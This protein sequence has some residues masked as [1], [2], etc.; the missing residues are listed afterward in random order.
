VG[1]GPHRDDPKFHNERTTDRPPAKRGRPP[2]LDEDRSQPYRERLTHRRR[3]HTLLQ[4]LD[5]SGS[6][7]FTTKAARRKARKEGTQERKVRTLS[8]HAEH[9][10]LRKLTNFTTPLP[11]PIH[12]PQIN[13]TEIK[14]AISANN[15]IIATPLTQA[16]LL[17]YNRNATRRHQRPVSIEYEIERIIT[18]RSTS[19]QQEFLCKW[20]DFPLHQS[21]WLPK[22]LLNNAQETLTQYLTP[23]NPLPNPINIC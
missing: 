22:K 15:P 6:P 17:A 3:V 13:Q 9:H 19:K 7:I 11:Q 21:S 18:D 8:L 14:N 20:K 12:I 23:P 4:L 1:I 5:E 2:K 16:A 10:K